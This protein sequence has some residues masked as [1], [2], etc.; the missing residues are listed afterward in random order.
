MTYSECHDLPLPTKLLDL[1]RNLAVHLLKT[2]PKVKD[3][4]SWFSY[5]KTGP[6]R[7]FA[8]RQALK[9][10]QTKPGNAPNILSE[11]ENLIDFFN[12]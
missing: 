10:D 1:S 8:R 3:P 5:L 9:P 7:V 11:I 6:T 4:Q 2:N 12:F